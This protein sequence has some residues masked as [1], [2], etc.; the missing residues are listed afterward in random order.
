ME[1]EEHLWTLLDSN[2][3]RPPS[4]EAPC[5]VQQVQAVYCPAF[6]SIGRRHTS[7]PLCRAPRLLHNASLVSNQLT[8]NSSL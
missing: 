4:T 6:L 1:P 3:R 8:V 7:T 2:Q 5:W